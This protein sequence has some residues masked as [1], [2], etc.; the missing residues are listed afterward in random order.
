[1]RTYGEIRLDKSSNAWV[2]VKVE[3]HVSIRLKQ[4]FPSIPKSSVPPYSL[5]HTMIVDADLDWFMQRYP[6][7]MPNDDRV[8]MEDGKR[9]FLNNQAEL[10]RILLPTYELPIVSGLREG[11]MIRPYQWQAIEILKRRGSLLVGDEVGLGK[12]YIAA[13]FMATEP[14][15]LPAAVVCDAHMQQQW[16]EK[17]EAFTYL[18]VHLIKKASAYSLP[19]ADVY[20][21]RISQVSGWAEI[22]ATGLFQS[23]IYDEPQS[24]RTG[25]QTN[26]GAACK[27]LSKHTKYRVGLT[28]TPI[29]NY[30]DE[31][32]HIMQFID[33]TVL[34]DWWDFVR[35]WCTQIG[36]GGKF[37][38]N[39]PKALGSYLREQFSMIRRLKSD[40]GQQLP[41]VSRIVEYI[42]YDEK[43]VNDIEEL[44]RTL[45]IKATTA[46]FV[47]RGSAMRDLDIMVRQ[48]T[49]VAKAKSVANFTRIIVESGEAVILFAWHRDVYDIFLEHL[50]D[51]NPALYTGSESANQKNEAKR[52]FTSGE[53]D[54]LIMSLRSGAGVDGLQYRCSTVVFGELDWSPGIHHQCI[55]RVDREGQTQ[56]VSAFFLVTNEGSDPPMM[57]VLGF[58]ASEA[59]AIIDPFA[60]IETV[61]N[62]TTNLRKLVDRYLDKK[63]KAQDTLG[64][65]SQVGPV[66]AA[67]AGGQQ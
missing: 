63:H 45:A 43:A 26:K 61:A 2:I 6:L 33:D 57:D 16:K 9:N 54:L 29:Y 31:M 18:R 56:P 38:I 52:K 20:I 28:A 21:F 8:I 37:R 17:I 14:S 39:N 22:F 7:E 25:C 47:E 30:G 15:A 24:L 51:L 32:W 12:S 66:I 58:K 3:P 40:V 67:K 5:P 34:G 46:S 35:E 10:E 27:V 65:W 19:P 11:E 4:L 48:T 49:G 53:T 50:R 55:G 41:K 36:Y 23:V 42:D 62:D 44:A 1:M 64:Q 13:G 60:D 59:H